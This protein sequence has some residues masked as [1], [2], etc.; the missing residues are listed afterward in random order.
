MLIISIGQNHPKI[1]PITLSIRAKAQVNQLIEN[2]V[3]SALVTIG[4]GFPLSFYAG[5]I[6]A[7]YMS[8]DAALNAAR[9]LI[10][11]LEQEWRFR[12]L[13]GKIPDPDSP[14]GKRSVFMSKVLS[15]NHL[16]WQLMQI[17]LQM[18]ELGHWKAAQELDRISF[19]IDDLRDEFLEKAQLKAEGETVGVVEYIADWHRRISGAKPSTW[20]ILKPWPNKRYT[21]LSCVSINE[22]TGEWHEVGPP[23]RKTVMDDPTGP[24]V[25]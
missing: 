22:A 25:S 16:S 15:G 7:R 8:F 14:T 18:K 21:S 6:V 3:I 4:I 11:N 20:R 1:K 2:I 13:N 19:E 24:S 9:S 5:V 17:G 10:L 23:K 12:Y